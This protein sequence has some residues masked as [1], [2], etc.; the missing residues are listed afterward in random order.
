MTDDLLTRYILLAQPGAYE[1]S[2]K[3]PAQDTRTGLAGDCSVVLFAPFAQI[4]VNGGCWQVA[5]EAG[6]GGR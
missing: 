2:E 1:T 5:S 3:K 4:G 6:G